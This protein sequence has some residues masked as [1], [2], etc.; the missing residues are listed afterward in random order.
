MISN[1]NYHLRRPVERVL[2]EGHPWVYRDAVTES[3]A[4]PGT[5][6]SVLGRDGRFCARGLAD[7][8]PIAVRVWTSR[9]EPLRSELHISFKL[10]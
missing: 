1:V 5:V 10:R 2:R 6:V 7:A 9:D 4:E 3:D 8:G